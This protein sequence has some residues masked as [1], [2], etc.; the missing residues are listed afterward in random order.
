MLRDIYA[1]QAIQTALLA[2]LIGHEGKR[3]W[4]AR[5]SVIQAENV[6]DFWIM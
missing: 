4:V 6:Q 3:N 5:V 1:T 2:L